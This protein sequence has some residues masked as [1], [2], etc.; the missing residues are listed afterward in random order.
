MLSKYYHTF[1]K[2]NNGRNIRY[3]NSHYNLAHF[4]YLFE[5]QSMKDVLKMTSE[6]KKK[7]LKQ[8][9]IIETKFNWF[10]KWPLTYEHNYMLQSKQVTSFGLS[11][12]SSSFTQ[13]SFYIFKFK[14]FQKQILNNVVNRM[15]TNT[16]L[17]STFLPR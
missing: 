1:M 15:K 17:K 3:T 10:T 12:F 11:F 9:K 7:D 13:L 4:C 8:H 2:S 5:T 16:L 6:E 14:T